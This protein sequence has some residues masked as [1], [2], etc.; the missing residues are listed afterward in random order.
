MNG[1]PAF[2]RRLRAGP[3]RR[4]LVAVAV[5]AVAFGALVAYDPS[6]IALVVPTMVLILGLVAAVRALCPPIPDPSTRSRLLAWTM[7][8]FGIHLAIGLIVWSSPSLTAY[9]GGDAQTYHSGGVSVLQH[10]QHVGPLPSL[11]SGK[12]GF[13]YLLAGLYWAFGPHAAAGLVVNAGLAAAIVP[14]L[15]D[16][17]RR[18][19]GSHPAHYVAPIATLLPGFLIWGSQL[20]REASIYFLMAVSLDC[21]VR[22][23]RRFS[24][25]GLIVM[26]STLALLFTLRADVALLFASALVIGI[27]VGRHQV[28]GGLVTGLG[29][30]AIVLTLVLGAGL[31]Y[32]GYQLVTHANLQQVN[33]IRTNSSTSASS[34][35]QPEANVSTPTHAA[36]YLPLGATYSLLGPFPWQAGSAR[37]L[38]A[39]PDALVWWFLLPS[40]W[41][42]LR[43]AGR[44]LG[45]GVLVYVLPAAALTVMLSLLVGNFGTTIRERMQVILILVPLIAVGWSLRTRSRPDR[46]SDVKSRHP[47]MV[48]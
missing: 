5:A 3:A 14:I 18:Q 15:Y 17:T 8:A 29:T 46:A 38:P 7:S 23:S 25:G 40:L 21:A 35:F 13:F 26:T 11:P 36:T 19:F 28:T 32:S 45:R 22:L 4:A 30:A 2:L 43:E 12:E 33:N 20:L 6:A 27:A 31:G 16:V 37:Q 44:R 41:R 34:G 42:G 39:V 48:G 47:A 9:L 10:W 1:S 24:L